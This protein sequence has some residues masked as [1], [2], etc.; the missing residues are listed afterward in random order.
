MRAEGELIGPIE[1]KH[2]A[3]R[4]IELV[5]DTFDLC[6]YHNVL[7]ESP[8]GRACAY[9]EMGR[10]AAPCDGSATM[11]DYWL[12]V[13]QSI[14]ALLHPQN[15]RAERDQ[16]MRQAAAE[17]NF[18]AAGKIKTHLE[19]GSRLH[20]GAFAHL[21]SLRDFRF[22]SLQRGPWK[23]TAKIF[24]ITPGRLAEAI[25]LPAPPSHWSSIVEVLR[26]QI[27]ASAELVDR[28]AAER[29]AIVASHLFSPRKQGVFLPWNEITEKALTKA[30]S[31]LEK[32]K[33]D[34]DSPDE[35][36]VKD[37]QVM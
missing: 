13:R 31:Q 33:V 28:P 34:L 1:D 20:A 19:R 6:R 23:S 36:M 9:K 32:Q 4:L 25:D 17:L 27:S 29:M 14:D 15:Y 12:L 5:E 18:E 3:G 30:Y 7:L 37:L 21:R 10:C 11:D 22:V 24:A 16:Q 26:D 8:K 2:A 35:G